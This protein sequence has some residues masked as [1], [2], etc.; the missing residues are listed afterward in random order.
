[1]P[2]KI[3]FY[4]LDIDMLDKIKQSATE[5]GCR[6]IDIK[7]ISTID[8]NLV[9]DYEPF[10]LSFYRLGLTVQACDKE[11]L[12]FFGYLYNKSVDDIVLLEELYRIEVSS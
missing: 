10:N 1:M 12:E 7:Y 5:S 9:Y 2:K 6:L 4:D 11:H 3:T 8:P